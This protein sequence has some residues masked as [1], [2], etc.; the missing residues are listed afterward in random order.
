MKNEDYLDGPYLESQHWT[1]TDRSLVICGFFSKYVDK[2]DSIL[3]LGCSAGRNLAYLKEAGYKNLTGLEMSKKASALCKFPVLTGRYEEIDHGEF[4][5]IFSASFLQE[6][7]D[8]SQERLNK[9]LEKCQKYF[10]IFGDAMPKFE[11][12]GFEL[13]EKRIVEPF[14]QAIMVFKRNEV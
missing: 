10:M 8:F 9:T 14:T 12:P 1:L 4:D 13:I 5:V 7:E 11:H 2:S 6:L 3:E